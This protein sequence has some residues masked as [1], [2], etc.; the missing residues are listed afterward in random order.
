APREPHTHAGLRSRSTTQR[1]RA[2]T[3]TFGSRGRAWVQRG[4]VEPRSARLR[5]RGAAPSRKTGRGDEGGP[6]RPDL[7][8]PSSVGALICRGVYDKY[9]ESARGWTVR[10]GASPT[11]GARN[12]T[13][14][15][16]SQ[17][18]TAAGATARVNRNADAFLES[19]LV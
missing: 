19:A 13:N 11:G 2:K 3:R 10:R 15:G 18:H 8:G 5:R 17:P 16:H 14:A 1:Q 7:G 6:R 12:T 9:D 4:C